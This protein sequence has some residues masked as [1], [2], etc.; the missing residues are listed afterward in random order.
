MKRRDDADGFLFDVAVTES[1]TTSVH[2]VTLSRADYDELGL[3]WG[4]PEGFVHGCF[5]F[6][7][8]REPKESILRRFD[9]REIGNYFPA[10]REE[11]LKPG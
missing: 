6:L 8:A 1:G 4:S 10:F 2:E 7:L 3:Q 11:I 5:V 9:V